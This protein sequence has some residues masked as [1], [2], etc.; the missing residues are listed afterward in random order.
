MFF[1]SEEVHQNL[2]EEKDSSEFFELL[3]AHQN[4]CSF[5]WRD[6]PNLPVFHRGAPVDNSKVGIRLPSHVLGVLQNSLDIPPLA[7]G[8]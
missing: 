7:M 5:F 3:Q 4:R 1:S 8:I 2:E 6:S